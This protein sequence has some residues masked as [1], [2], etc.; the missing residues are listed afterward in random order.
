[1]PLTPRRA[2]LAVLA[3][4]LASGCATKQAASKVRWP[5]EP[6]PAR[7]RFVRAIT[8]G[9]DVET[10]AWPG[11][12][13]ALTGSGPIVFRQPT[14]LAVAADGQRLYMTDQSLG[15]VLW[16]DFKEGRA[17]RVAGDYGFAQPFGLAL[18]QA[19]NVYVGEPPARRVRVF[20]PAGALLRQFGGEAERPTGIAID[21]KRQLVYVA[22]GSFPTSQNHRVLVYSQAGELLRTIGSRGTAPGQFN[23][24][25]HLAVDGAGNLFVVDTLNFRVQVFDPEGNLV[26]FFGEPGASLGKFSRPKGIAVDKRDIVYV[27]DGDTASVQ[28][29]NEQS[30][31]LM[32]FGGRAEMFEYFDLPGPIAVDRA[33]KYIYVGE[34]SAFFP[35]IN[36]YEFLEVA[37]PPAPATAP[38]AAPGTTA[39]P[40]PAATPAQPQA[41][42][43]TR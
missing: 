27:V 18:D 13:R 11:F 21:Q 42:T 29:F 10:S 31:L 40:A 35:R 34:Q 30:Q 20:S 3:L 8:S 43:P 4:A 37:E 5:P 16:F 26:R 33:G 32:Y 25:A 19:G 17:G 39:A 28:L 6:D 24:P 7:I 22:D 36:V 1:M 9:A 15:Q 41:P 2:I 12:Q 38:A 23:F 14:V